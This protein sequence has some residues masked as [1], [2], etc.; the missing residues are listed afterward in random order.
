MIGTC[1]WYEGCSEPVGVGDSLCAGHRARYD[2]EIAAAA[3]LE[4]RVRWETARVAALHNVARLAR[5][6]RE[7]QAFAD[8]KLAERNDAIRD[9]AQAFPV[10]RPLK[11]VWETPGGRITKPE[12]AKAA[13]VSR[14]MVNRIVFGTDD[15]GGTR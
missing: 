10:R 2:R 9:A 13:G 7:A 6:A 3:R 14:T 5:E 8:A 11:E 12:L 1:T 15:D 4:R